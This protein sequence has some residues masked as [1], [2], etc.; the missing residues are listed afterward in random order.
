MRINLGTLSF[1]APDVLYIDILNVMYLLD[2][3]FSID[4][5]I[6]SNRWISFEDFLFVYTYELREP[7]WDFVETGMFFNNR[8][9][10]RYDDAVYMVYNKYNKK[11]IDPFKEQY[12]YIFK[13]MNDLKLTNLV[14][15]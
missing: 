5:D 4:V 6:P 2:L 13:N 9:F 14:R 12:C 8:Y 11:V 1:E 10:F 7:F 15:N 3:P